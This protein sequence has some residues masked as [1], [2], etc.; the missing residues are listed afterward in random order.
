MIQEN[1]M[2]TARKEDLSQ[3]LSHTI[4]D[5]ET[6]IK[7]LKDSIAAAKAAIAELQVNLQRANENRK[8]ENL[9]YQSVVQAQAATKAVLHKA[10]DRLATF[11]DAELLQKKKQQ[12]PPEAA[13]LKGDVRNTGSSGVMSMIEK[14]IYDC[15][16]ITADSLKG[17]QEAQEQ[18]ET[19]VADS[20][21]SIKENT[22]AVTTMSARK[23]EAEKELTEKQEELEAT[24]QELEELAKMN[25]NIRQKARQSEIEALQQ[26]KQILSG[27][28]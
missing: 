21:A 15:D 20:N 10:L 17:E 3:D 23:A 9:E 26:A 13:H 28:M 12:P 4:E 7:G 16:E 22:E 18:Y 25:F 24:M 1:E 14:L 2:E 6:E 11:Y 27:A 8:A 5:L 19:F